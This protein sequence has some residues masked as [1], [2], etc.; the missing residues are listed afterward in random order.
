MTLTFRRWLALAPLGLAAVG[1][2]P[3]RSRVAEPVAA[4]LDTIHPAEIRAHTSYLADDL[5]E[6]RDAG[7][8]GYDLA[9]GY[10]RAQFEAMGLEPAGEDGG[11]YQQVPLRRARL[12]EQESSIVLIDAAGGAGALRYGDDFVLRPSFAEE[13]SR[14]RAPLVFVGYGIHAPEL[15]HDDYDGVDVEGK[16]VVYVSGAPESFAST[17]RAVFS[18]S[19][20]KAAQAR[21]RGAVGMLAIQSDVDQARRPW[22]RMRDGARSAAMSWLDPDSRRPTTATAALRANGTLSPEAARRLVGDEGELLPPIAVIRT[23]SRHEDIESPNVVARIAGAS[24]DEA[25]VYST[26]LDHVGRGREIDGDDIYNGAY[27]NASGVAAL[28]AVARAFAATDPPPNRDILFLAATAEEK[29]LL[30]SDFFA[31]HPTIPRASIIANINADAALMFHPLHDIVAFGAEH[32]SLLEPVTRAA[33]DL[34][35]ALSPDFMPEEVVFVR[36]DQYSFVK[37]GI[38]AVYPFV[39]TDTGN[40]RVDGE[41]ILREWMATRYH[42][43]SDDMTQ[44]MDF[45]AGADY[46][47]LFYLIGYYVANGD[48]RPEWNDGDFLGNLYARP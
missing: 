25:V 7:T 23:V 46:A 36:S 26:H 6:G 1:C 48:A 13:E 37:Q 29:G 30:G 11:Y 15:D 43:P 4:V 42:K 19:G 27:D 47:K 2:V 35:I 5:L 12:D 40:D 41:A 28:L 21:E 16:I 22:A 38:P 14:V 45:Q 32:S 20:T 24:S 9:A 34:D 10:V 18:S 8:R 33:R 3:E 44:E 39:G 31:H 17:E